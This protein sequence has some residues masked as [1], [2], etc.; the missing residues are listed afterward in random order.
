M[1]KKE[2]TKK[3]TENHIQSHSVGIWAPLQPSWSHVQRQK[4]LSPL[5]INLKG[6]HHHPASPRPSP[7]M[8]PVPGSSQ[9]A[10]HMDSGM[11]RHSKGKQKHHQNIFTMLML[12]QH[13]L[14]LINLVQVKCRTC[15]KGRKKGN[16]AINLPVPFSI[17]I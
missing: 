2:G 10:P 16:I 14:Y 5:Q 12:H 6:S 15:F 1:C 3:I 11:Q 7:P 4:P 9:S 17:R 8:P 13:H